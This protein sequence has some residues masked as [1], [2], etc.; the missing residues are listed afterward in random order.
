MHKFS[1]ESEKIRALTL[2]K[3]WDEKANFFKVLPFVSLSK[4]HQ[5]G[6]LSDARELLGYV[7][8]YLGLP[9]KNKGY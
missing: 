2:K 6:K 7:P 4:N 5:T 3:L 1:A 8:W 9:P